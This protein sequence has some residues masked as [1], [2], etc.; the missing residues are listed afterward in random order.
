MVQRSRVGFQHTWPQRLYSAIHPETAKK[1][2]SAVLQNAHQPALAARP[3]LMEEAELGERMSE[4]TRE[5]RRVHLIQAR[6]QGLDLVQRNP[7]KQQIVL[8]CSVPGPKPQSVRCPLH[9]MT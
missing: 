5:T 4:Y 9:K 3:R 1:V 6:Q 7:C 8:R 2:R